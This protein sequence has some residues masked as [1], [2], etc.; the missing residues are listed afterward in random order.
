M[1]GGRRLEPYVAA[2]SPVIEQ[3]LLYLRHGDTALPVRA[4]AD[5]PSAARAVGAGLA[6]VRGVW[7]DEP[8]D[9][10]FASPSLTRLYHELDRFHAPL[11]DSTWAEWHYFSIAPSADEWWYVTFLT[12]GLWHAGRAGGRL[13]VTR[14]RPGRPDA[15]WVSEVPQSA[16]Q[17]DTTRADLW[18]GP[19]VVT[20][21]EGRYRLRGSASGRAGTLRF[22]L[23]LVGQ[24]GAYVPPVE[25]ADEGFVSGYVVPVVRGLVRGTICENR[26][27]RELEDVPA[28]HDHNWGVWRETTWDWGQARGAG[29][30][31]VYGGV[32]RADT[33]PAASPPY[34]LAVVDSL[35]IRRIL[36]FRAI[37]YERDPR[38]R[39][40]A[41]FRLV[42]TRDPDT[43]A[44]TVDVLRA[45]ATP[46]PVAG[47]LRVFLQLRGAFRVSGSLSGAAVADSG[48]GFFE[49]FAPD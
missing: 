43:V 18:L 9:R 10:D 14:H 15:E 44:L 24:P 26:Q 21:R 38:T 36:R 29:M 40:P 13:L 23:E 16:V 20:Q 12:G 47:R 8:G 32:L 27:C 31:L 42:A 48:L 5:I 3:E 45:Q 46:T 34:F 41:Q 22:D 7:D 33:A 30:S 25:V 39:V 35:G 17:I 4:G 1:I 37:A 6:P 19:H 2:T 49:T 11:S 28:Y